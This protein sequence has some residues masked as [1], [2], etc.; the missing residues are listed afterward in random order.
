MFGYKIQSFNKQNLMEPAEI[1]NYIG[2]AASLFVVLSFAVKN[3]LKKTRIINL[4]GCICFVIY[5]FMKGNLWPVIIPNAFVCFLQF[6]H[7]LRKS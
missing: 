2:Y 1:G 7:L 3:N 5:G 6:Y 4:I